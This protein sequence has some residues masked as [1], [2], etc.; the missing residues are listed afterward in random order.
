MNYLLNY[1]TPI[2]K[3]LSSDL[4]I[5]KF[6]ISIYIFYKQKKQSK[7]Y[8]FHTHKSF[9][10]ANN[11]QSKQ[12]S[13]LIAFLST[14]SKPISP[15]SYYNKIVVLAVVLCAHTHCPFRIIHT[16]PVYNHL[17]RRHAS[18]PMW[19]L[20]SQRP[21]PPSSPSPWASPR[22][23]GRPGRERWCPYNQMGNSATLR[24]R[25]LDSHSRDTK[26]HLW[27]CATYIYIR[28]NESCNH[29]RINMRS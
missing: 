17:A 6:I 24:L 20:P 28:R 10:T 5:F 19:W 21:V 11:T 14:A 22:N 26:S 23:C 8:S 9:K 13:H 29:L 1:T 7:K 16:D 15:H 3:N 12:T 4:S 18:V 25:L 27:L 2:V